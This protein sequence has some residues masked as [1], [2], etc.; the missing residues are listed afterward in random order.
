MSLQARPNTSRH[1]AQPVQTF[2]AVSSFDL[3]GHVDIGCFT[4]AVRGPGR[5][6]AIVEIVVADV[7]RTG[8][9]AGGGKID[10]ARVKFGGRRG[11]EG[12]FEELEEQEVREMVCAE[13]GFESV[14]CFDECRGGH[15]AGVVDENIQCRSLREDG[16]C[17]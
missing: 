1:D 3:I 9:V 14:G 16:L 15:D 5:V 17:G 4:A 8:A 12:S 7:D 6:F 10:D 11:E 2:V 13:L